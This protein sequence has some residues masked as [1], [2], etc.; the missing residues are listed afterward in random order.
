MTQHLVITNGDVAAQRL[1]HLGLAREVQPWRDILYEGPVP[2]TASLAALS[3]IRAN[4]LAAAYP[5]PA[6]DI[7]GE[8]AERDARITQ[9]TTFDTITL[10]FE[11][12]LADMLQLLQILDA[13]AATDRDPATLHLIQAAHPLDHYTDDALRQLAET[14]T[15]VGR[16]RLNQAQRSWAAWRAS[17]HRG[18][19]AQMHEPR[20]GLLN[21]WSTVLHTKGL[22]PSMDSGLTDP[23]VSIVH[24]VEQGISQPSAI[25]TAILNDSRQYS[26]AYMSDWSLYR[27]IDDLAA[28]PD[29]LLEGLEGRYPCGGNA[30]ARDAYNARHIALT[31]LGRAVLAGEANAAVVNGIDRWIGGVRIKDTYAPALRIAHDA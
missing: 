7:A 4:Y 9:H 23:E 17:D 24:C 31:D 15:P 6:R 12:D 28:A 14:A 18:W 3:H 10:W 20:L 13:F 8:F 26:D 25:V 19:F 29:P 30:A 27:L 21:L 22:Y 1:E 16:R 5:Q 2:Q 11:S